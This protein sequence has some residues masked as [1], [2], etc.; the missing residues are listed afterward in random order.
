MKDFL[1]IYIYFQSAIVLRCRKSEDRKRDHWLDYAGPKF[2]SQLIN[3]TKVLLKIM[4]VFLP[5][6]L[7][8]SLY[9]QQSSRWTFQAARL[10]GHI[11][12]FVIK[13]DQIQVLNPIFILMFI[14]IFDLFFY[15]L[16]AKIG[17]RR[18]LQKMAIGGFLAAL[19][20]MI[21]GILDIQIERN[22]P[23]IALS[24]LW[25]LP[26]YLAISL[27]EIMFSVTGMIF[28][29]SHAPSSMKSVIQAIWLLTVAFGNLIDVLIIGLLRFKTQ[30]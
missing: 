12:Y 10:N 9:E 17:V 16:L 7:F 11:G 25:Q 28:S 29:Y 5:I 6:P 18:P 21:S 8:W 24:M 14:P 13:P 23:A 20:F 19:A 27:G 22:S 3:D 1:N 2:D 4:F 26:Q 30:V 15:P